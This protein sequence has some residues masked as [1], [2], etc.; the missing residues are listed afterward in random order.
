MALPDDLKNKILQSVEDGF[1]QQLDYT[2]Q[3]VNLPSLR[4][5]EH[6]IQDL[7]FREF[8]SRGYKVDRFDMDPEAIAAHPGGS[9]FSEHHSDAPIVVGIHHP[10]QETGRSL[11]LNAHLDVVPEGPHEMWSDDPFSGK[12]EGD[13]MFGRGGADM[14]AGA[15]ANLAALDALRRIGLQPAATVYI[16]SVVEEES[17][18]NG[19]L[20]TWLRG[21]TADAVLIPEPED[22][23]LVRANVGVIWFHS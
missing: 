20:M 17:T 19:A 23:M 14:K 7:T 21:Y 22:E 1:A 15:A 12:I 4:G 18:G 2:R 3:L 11:I 13:W 10:R 16:Q 9:P 5:Q 6:A 8:Q